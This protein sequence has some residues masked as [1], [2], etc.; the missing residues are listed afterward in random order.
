M[1]ALVAA[2]NQKSDPLARMVDPDGPLPPAPGSTPTSEAGEPVSKEDGVR[3]H[4]HLSATFPASDP[5]S[6]EEAAGSRKPRL[7]GPLGDSARA[8]ERR[9]S[10]PDPTS[11]EGAVAPEKAT[12]APPSSDP[13]SEAGEGHGGTSAVGRSRGGRFESGRPTA[14]AS[15]STSGPGPGE[16][17]GPDPNPTDADAKEG[18]AI[19][20]TNDEGEGS[21]TVGGQPPVAATASAGPTPNPSLIQAWC[22]ENKVDIRIARVAIRRRH[23][24]AYKD[25][26][27]WKDFRELK[28]ERETKAIRDLDEW[29][30]DEIKGGE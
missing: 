18:D 17:L 30:K 21:V 5:T 4:D 19:P 20:D 11:G 2:I 29:F 3:G 14:P 28:G 12:E 27:D 22:D 9:A 7:D 1:D 23:K 26:Q 25:I 6:V 13:T 16:R 24:T 8:G 15:G 10:S